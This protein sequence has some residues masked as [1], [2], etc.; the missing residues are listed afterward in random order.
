MTYSPTLGSRENVLQRGQAIVGWLG[1]LYVFYVIL[2]VL[3]LIG[4]LL[5]MFSS[6]L[7]KDSPMGSAYSIGVLTGSIIPGLVMGF[8]YLWAIRAAQGAIRS[9]STYA[10]EG[11][12]PAEFESN[13]KRMVTWLTVGQVLG[14]ISG[15]FSVLIGFSTSSFLPQE[16]GS[17]ASGLLIALPNIIAGVISVVL[18][19]LIFGAVKSFFNSVLARSQGNATAVLPSANRAASWLQFVYILQWIGVVFGILGLLAA[20]FVSLAAGQQVNSGF[21][22]IFLVIMIPFVA[23]LAWLVSLALRLTGHS[24]L[25]ALDVATQLDQSQNMPAGTALAPDP[26][27]NS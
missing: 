17:T 3:Y 14:V 19:W 20:I 9:V 26:W 21:G 23:F 13:I 27:A 18:S 16:T 1:Q 11:R 12:V 6:S 7:L 8:L 24:R 2:I 10:G 5:S 4:F 22:I 25:F 15:I